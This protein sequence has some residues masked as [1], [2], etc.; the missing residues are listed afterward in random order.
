MPFSDPLR[1]GPAGPPPRPAACDTCGLSEPLCAPT[2][3]DWYEPIRLACG[4]NET[5]GPPTVDCALDGTGGPLLCRWREID[6]DAHAPSE[7]I[8]RAFLSGCCDGRCALPIDVRDLA[9]FI[10]SSA[11][12]ICG[13]A[14]RLL[15][16]SATKKLLDVARSARLTTIS[17][18]TIPSSAIARAPPASRSVGFFDSRRV[19]CFRP[20]SDGRF[21][22]IE[23][24]EASHSL[25]LEPRRHAAPDAPEPP[26]SVRSPRESSAPTW[27]LGP[28]SRGRSSPIMYV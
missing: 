20:S 23:S 26:E 25:T 3:P 2:C 7:L 8:E 15:I 11:A 9:F 6:G 5:L 28:A 13:S 24:S 12:E 10:L 22:C 14:S 4:V 27:T 1:A 16:E 18:S 19:G 21:F 17:S